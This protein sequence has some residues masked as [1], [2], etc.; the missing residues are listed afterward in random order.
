MV[1]PEFSI[2]VPSRFKSSKL[3]KKVYDRLRNESIIRF[4]DL[5]YRY[6]VDASSNQHLRFH[7]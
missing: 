7:H 1:V 6:F 5:A 2:N 4:K 3:N